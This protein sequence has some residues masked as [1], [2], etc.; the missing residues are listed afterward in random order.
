MAQQ[1]TPM[2]TT[3][4]APTVDDVVRT[5]PAPP[6]PDDA[7][8][9]RASAPISV[10][11]LLV[12]TLYTGE[13]T[14][15]GVADAC[16]CR[17]RMLEPLVERAARRAADRGAAAPPGSGTAGYRYA[18]TDLGRDRARQ[19]LDANQYV[20]PAP[21]PLAGYVAQMQDAAADARG[22]IDRERLRRGFSHL[23]VDDDML[24]QLGPA[25]QRGQGAVPLR[26]SR[27]RQDRDR[28][29]HGARARRRHVHAARDRRRR[30]DRSRCST[31]STT[32]RSKPTT[33]VDEHRRRRRR[34]IAAGCAS[35]GRS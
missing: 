9:D 30:P 8:G 1:V 20:G 25:R 26:P 23:I 7:R 28:R 11:Q 34:A 18:L 35:G 31:R 21:V 33:D 4:D 12:K 24:E 13:A 6:R 16:G 5:A 22:Y 29:G 19:Y 10:E 14:G 3:V 15:I 2:A 27:Q 32:S 17:S